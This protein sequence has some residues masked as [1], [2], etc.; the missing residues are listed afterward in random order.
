M[1]ILTGHRGA[2]KEFPE[3]T[4]LSI[5]N[6]IQNGCKAIEIDIHQTKDSQLVVIHDPTIDRT[7]NGRGRVDSYTYQE[8]LEF[9]FGQGQQIPTLFEVLELSKKTQMKLLIELKVHGIEKQI[10][11][12][13][14][15]FKLYENT[16]IISF[17]H[18][19]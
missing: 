6:A 4:I 18:S 11:T 3:N 12:L 17:H 1:S 10:V 13:I 14:D 15:E 2:K 19:I 5:E 8:L 9:D 7:S 16:Y